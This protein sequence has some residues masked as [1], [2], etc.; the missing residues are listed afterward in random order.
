MKSKGRKVKQENCFLML[1]INHL[2]VEKNGFH[3]G[4]R[5]GSLPA[6]FRASDPAGICKNDLKYMKT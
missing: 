1:F 6:I 2:E 3:G 5:G 4:F